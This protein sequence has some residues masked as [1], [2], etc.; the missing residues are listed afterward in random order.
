MM[1]PKNR[2]SSGTAVLYIVIAE[3][4]LAMTRAGVGAHRRVSQLA[5]VA[6]LLPRIVASIADE[7]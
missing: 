2:E 6:W 3:F 1:I 4:P 7:Q 5:G